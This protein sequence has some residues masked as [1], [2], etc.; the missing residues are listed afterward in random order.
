MSFDLIELILIFLL[1]EGGIFLIFLLHSSSRLYSRNIVLALF[2]L[3]LLLNFLNVFLLNYIDYL[4]NLGLVFGLLYGPLVLIYIDA[5]LESNFKF[6]FA[7]LYHTLPALVLLVWILTYDLQRGQTPA[8][9]LVLIG[10]IVFL[11]VFFYLF[12]SYDKIRAYRLKLTSGSSYEKKAY[13]WL[14]Y[15]IHSLSLLLLL[16]AI[17]FFLHQMASIHFNYSILLIALTTLFLIIS[18][19]LKGLH[20]VELFKGEAL[21]KYENSLLSR[22]KSENLFQRLT[23]LMEKEQPYLKDDLSL[24]SLA[25]M[26]D[27][28]PRFLSQVINENAKQ[29]FFEFIN[30]YRVQ[31]AMKMLQ[32]EEFKA[33]RI[34]EIMYQVG[35]KSR[36]S[37]HMAFKKRT[38]LSPKDYRKRMI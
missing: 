32:K 3:N 14:R 33:H 35:F 28:H 34:F 1:A 27:I 8:F 13:S 2:V 31:E 22:E 6:R 15:F 4:P 12:K 29:N 11:Q 9:E 23:G 10:V 26:L 21:M 5:C 25:E 20:Q 38:G 17:E 30:T 16:T 7:Q 19:I 18:F 24:H 37:F 36:S